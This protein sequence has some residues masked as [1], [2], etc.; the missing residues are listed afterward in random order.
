[1]PCNP[2]DM[3]P[4][5]V[6]IHAV[7]LVHL[8]PAG[9]P[10]F[11]FETHLLGCIHDAQSTVELTHPITLRI[12]SFFSLQCRICHARKPLAE[13][14]ERMLYVVARGLHARTA[15]KERKTPPLI[16]TMPEIRGC[17]MLVP[18]HILQNVYQGCCTVIGR[19]KSSTEV[20]LPGSAIGGRLINSVD[21]DDWRH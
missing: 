21:P 9:F 10:S 20:R 13:V 16:I 5:R 6:A 17:L 12:K 14:V 3:S 4:G 2:S 1:M 8:Y 15:A 18:K 11:N 7:S 19:K